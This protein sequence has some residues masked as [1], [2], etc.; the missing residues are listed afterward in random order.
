MKMGIVKEKCASPASAIYS[1][2]LQSELESA[3]LAQGLSWLAV[4]AG[5]VR[6]GTGFQGY[7]ELK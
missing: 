7:A 3:H 4:A 5:G 1:K 2:I 6:L